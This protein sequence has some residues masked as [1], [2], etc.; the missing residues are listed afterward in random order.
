MKEEELFA[1][2]YAG[3]KRHPHMSNARRAAQFAPFAA[4]SGYEEAIAES[5]RVV[6]ERIELHEDALHTIQAK[7]AILLEHLKE[8]PFVSFLVFHEDEKQKGGSY[9][10]EEGHL[11]TVDEINRQF[12][13]TDRRKVN[14]DDVSS[15]DSPLFEDYDF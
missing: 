13:F 12:V 5:G 6:E 14:M 8:Q 11:K 1:Y 4:L 10:K 15:I 3:V 9:R 2:L 7:T